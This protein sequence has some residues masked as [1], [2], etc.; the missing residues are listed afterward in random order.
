MDKLRLMIIDKWSLMEVAL[1][2]SIALE[3]SSG[4][5]MTSECVE[6]SSFS[7]SMDE[8]NK[9]DRHSL[10]VRIRL[11]GNSG[12]LRYKRRI[13]NTNSTEMSDLKL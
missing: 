5:D 7:T 3:M 10:I 11:S 1:P 4:P 6:A 2:L 13:R 8:C 9:E 12:S